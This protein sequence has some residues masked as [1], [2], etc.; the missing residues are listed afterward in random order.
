ML[1]RVEPQASLLEARITHRHLISKDSFYEKLA[2]YG[3]E[4]ISDDDFA[5]LYSRDNGRPSI[6][7]SIMTRA[8]LCA[9]HDKVE[10]DR[11]IARRTRVDLDWKA[12]M[13]VPADFPGIAATT[14]S[15]FRSRLLVNDDDRAIFERT[16][17]RA[18]EA[19][20]MAG[21]RT[22][23]I[24]SA[25][26]VG[27]GAVA[28][29]YT[30]IRKLVERLVRVAGGHLDEETRAAAE[31]FLDGKPR[32]DWQDPQARR[33]HL[34]ELVAAATVVREATAHLDDA[35]IREA[36]GLIGAV[37]DQ[38]VEADEQGRPQIRRG[39]ARDR[40]ISHSDPEMRHGR[41]SKSRRFDGHKLH[42][43][44]DEQ[45]ELVLGVDIGPGNGGDGQHAAPLLR[46]VNT[47]LGGCGDDTTVTVLIGDM[48][49]SD[50]DVRSD[51]DK[52]GAVMVAK[53]P[54]VHNGGRF[55][56]IDFAIDLDA[57]TVTC[58]QNKTTDRSHA[59]RDHKGRPA[60]RFRF[61]A[62]V[63]QVCP[64]RD[65]CVKGTGG[66]T[67]TVGVHEQRIQAARTAQTHD[68]QTITLIR[69]RAKVERKVDHLQDLG[70]SK[71]RYYGLRKTRLQ[72]RLAATVAN[73]KRL[74]VLGAWA[75]PPQTGTQ[76]A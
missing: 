41:K 43:V 69:A 21:G 70:M 58:P 47:T 46:E 55:T 8:L 63:C 7:P 64:L 66:R 28:D 40:I 9:V 16:I 22:A 71:A 60:R 53:V 20:I 3:H 56:K 74:A 11:E 36:S 17:A 57:G 54:D 4:I 51:V 32:F 49:Y 75:A 48:A 67:I 18:V 12:A 45:T 25:P 19:G 72:A 1:G 65:Q 14:F 76:A 6:P 61:D 34:G 2:D 15:L 5:H 23:I 62:E 10:G 39:V 73:L 33:Q 37:I 50:G 27:A 44:T 26:V 42:L 68:P 30:L 38:D 59:C 13:G 24:D 52:L 31:P 29:T 35:K